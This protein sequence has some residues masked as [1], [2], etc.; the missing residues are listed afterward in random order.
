MKL[1]LALTIIL[2]G[3]LS[4]CASPATEAPASQPTEASAPVI[5]SPVGTEAPVQPT[6]A[7]T[8][9]PEAGQPA[10]V[11]FANDILPILQSRCENCHGGQKIEE[12]L[13]LKTYSDLMAGSDN[14]P[15]I[16]PGDA[17]NSLLVKLSANL[18][19]PKKGPKLTPPQIQLITD[20][21]NQGALD[22]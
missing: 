10:N 4:A 8:T 16:V 22:N 17:G 9:A 1:K 15:V 18:E 11:S 20:W 6:E 21:V 3:L 13:V 19:M 7:P 12:G 2:V 5:S 14:G